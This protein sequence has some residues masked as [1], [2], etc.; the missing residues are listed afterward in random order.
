MKRSPLKRK[1]PLRRVSKKRAKDSRIYLEKRKAFLLAHPICQVW[2]KENG[3]ADFAYP[4]FGMYA[5]AESPYPNYSWLIA[6]SEDL[7]LAP[8]STEVHHTKGRG[9]HYLDEKTW[10]AVST[11]GHRKIHQNPSWAR[12]MGFLK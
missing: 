12:K 9:K 10:L 1:T 2:L 3:W 4:M 8:R 7:P 5:K 6:D 11:E